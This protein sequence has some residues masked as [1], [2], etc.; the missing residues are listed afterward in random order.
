MKLLVY[1]IRFIKKI[2]LRL[3]FTFTC[4]CKYI[5]IRIYI[6]NSVLLVKLHLR[7]FN[8]FQM[9]ME[10]WPSTNYLNISTYIC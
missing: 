4:T 6:L 8:N 2:V 7:I 10:T 5:Y 1:E 3:V 9:A